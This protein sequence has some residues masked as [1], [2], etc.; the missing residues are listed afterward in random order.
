MTTEHDAALDWNALLVET[1]GGLAGWAVS[2]SIMP[3]D[4]L[5]LL[6]AG[7]VLFGGAWSQAL[8]AGGNRERP[9]RIK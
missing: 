8:G 1:A 5:V 2:P 7:C 4:C 9:A 6:P 3:H